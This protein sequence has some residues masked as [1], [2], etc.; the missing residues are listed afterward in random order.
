MEGKIWAWAVL[1]D[2][3][4]ED[5]GARVENRA[6]ILYSSL[7]RIQSTSVP[8]IVFPRYLILDPTSRAAEQRLM[9]PV[10]A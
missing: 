9:W 7:Q 2:S 1:S 4:H 10:V 5:G 6:T 3:R 8:M